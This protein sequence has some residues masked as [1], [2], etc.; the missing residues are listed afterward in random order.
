[1]QDYPEQFNGPKEIYG[2]PLFER[3]LQLP[4]YFLT[5]SKYTEE[6]VLK[7]QSNAKVKT[8]GVGV[9]TRIFHPGRKVANSNIKK[10]MV[11]LKKSAFKG[12]EVAIKTLNEVNKSL[13]IHAILLGDAEPLKASKPLFPYTYLNSVDDQTLAG[14]YSSADVFLF[15]SYTEGFGLPPLEAM[16][17]GTPVVTTDCIGNRD[18]SIDR[19]N[20][21]M[22]KP[23]D[24]EALAQA[25]IMVLTNETLRLRLSTE[26]IETAKNWTWIKTADKF[27]E[28]F[29]RE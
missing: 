23:G 10:I 15:T 26:G 6:I 27:E 17:C 13:S 29:T 9:N 20:C 2:L 7:H 5:N 14:L 4:F 8:V 16:A 28:A 1:M 3:T 25:I 11:I 19:K 12:S 18:Y 22:V 21:L 24:H